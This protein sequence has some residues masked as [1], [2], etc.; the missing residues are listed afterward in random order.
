MQKSLQVFIWNRILLSGILLAFSPLL[1]GQ[2]L[3]GPMCPNELEKTGTTI[4]TLQSPGGGG[5]HFALMAPPAA[6]LDQY[7]NGPFD[8]P[9]NTCTNWVNGN[10]GEQNS[11]YLEGWSIPYRCV[12]TD[13]PL[14]TPITLT[15]GYDIKHS[16]KH[17][18]DYLTYFHRMS[19]H[20]VFCD[21]G[22]N[23]AECVTPANGMFSTF[24]IPAPSSAG[25]PVP[26]MPAASF[27]ALPAGEREMRLYGGVIDAITY[28]TEGNLNANQAETTINIV[29]R[30]TSATATLAW[31]GH[32]ASRLDW[33]EG[34][35]AGGIGGSPYHMR[36]ENWTLNNL[37]NQ[38]RSLSGGAVAPVCNI[39]GPD[40]LCAG[41]N[42]QY[43]VSNQ[44][45]I[46]YSWAVIS[47]GATIIGSNTGNCV[48]IQAG[49][50]D[51]TLEAT[52]TSNSGLC[53]N[54][55][56]EVDVQ[57]AGTCTI[58]GPALLCPGASTQYCG[59]IGAG[60]Y[61][62]S[63]S[64]AASIVGP[65]DGQCVTVLAD[66]NCNSSFTLNLFVGSQP[67][68]SMCFKQVPVRDITAPS[69][70]CPDDVTVSCDS[71]VPAVNTAAV[72]AGDNCGGAVTVTHLGD[73]PNG[74]CPKIITRTYQAEDA[75][76]N[77]NSCDQL[78]RVDDKTAPSI[79]CP[80]DVTVS[81]DSEVP[82]VNTAAVTAGDNCGGAVTV[83]HLG[84]VPSGSCP[85]IITR[86]YQAE[87]ACGNL[88]S[89]D[90]LITVDDKTAPS[91]TCP[92]DVTVTC[93]SDVL[94]ANVNDVTGS[95][96]CGGSVTVTHLGDVPSG[97]CPKIITRTYQ[98][99]DACGN[100]NSCDQLITVDDKTAPSITCPA[101]VTVTCDSDV[102]AANVND[103]TG[104]D[105]CGGSV[106]VTHLGDVP[107]GSCPK[108]ITRTYQAEDACGNLN[109]C[110]QLITVDDKT[111]PAITCPDNVTVSCDS[112]VPAVDV[113][114]VT[115][116]DN[117]GGSVTVTHL[118]DV[119][120]GSCP[121]IITRTYQAEDACGNLN[122]CDQL[123]TVDDKTAPAITC[124]DNVTVSC[125]S[126]VP[127]VD[128]D[129]V[130]A[131]DNCG[132]SVTVTHL[133]DVPNGSCPKI[134]TRT[135]QAEDA[136]G[137]LNS[138]D[139]L[140]TVD[141]KTAPAIT[142]PENVTVSCDSNV[143][144][145]DV[146]DVTASDNC[147][148]SVTVTHLG[149]V[150]NGSCP[151]IITRT[152]QA[153]DAC[154]NLNS[155]DQLITVDD[156][157]APSI[158]CPDN[159]TVSCDS[160]V[161]AVD[162]DDVTASDNCGGSVTVTHLDDVPNGSC[163]KIITRIY[164][165]EDAC[166][167]L[168]SCDQLITVDDK[169]APS[170]TCP[171]NVTVSCTSE[172][173]DV[174]VDDVTASDNCNGVVV[175]EH[176]SDD[177]SGVVC[178]DRY[179]VKRKYKATDACGNTAVC[180]Q[181]I[182]VYDDTPPLISCPADVTVSCTSEVPAA[183]VNDVTTSDNCGGQVNVTYVG[184]AVTDYVC[185]NK[186]KITR[187]YRAFDACGKSS[188]CFQYIRV[189]DE[190]PPSGTCPAD[191][192][193]SCV[194]DIPCDENDPKMEQAIEQ[195]KAAYSDNCGGDIEVT[196][197]S[198]GLVEGCSY[199]EGSGYTY[200]HAF[201]FIVSDGC[202]NSTTCE[203]RFSGACV[204]TY[205]QGFWGNPRGK[206]N[207]LN[208]SQILDTLMKLGPIF[209]G[210]SVDCGFEVKTWQ[211][212]LGILPAGGPSVPLEKNYK[213]N[214][215]K[216][217][218][219]NLVGQLIA[220]QL[221]VRYNEHFRD[222]HL[223]SL[224]LAESCALL[225]DAVKALGLGVDTAT[226]ADLIQL[227]NTYLASNCNGKVYPNGYGGQLTAALTALNE[228][229]DECR[230]NMPCEEDPEERAADSRNDTKVGNNLDN[231]TL[232]PNPVLSTLTVRMD[233]G[234]AGA[235]DL[236]CFDVN[237]RL[238][239][240]IRQEIASG[241]NALTIDVSGFKPG[242]YWLRV[243]NQQAAVTKR[244]VVSR[245]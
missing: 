176:L 17:A 1:T 210:D 159:V 127:A 19:P 145:V 170:I 224:I 31:G 42:A 32:I 6:N 240:L 82:A 203:V 137:N 80:D 98:A 81:C 12:M 71:E 216:K 244:F 207:G 119:P 146:D 202:G 43:C 181:V 26:G 88:N 52:L 242:I 191:I 233:S 93:D 238:I 237:G 47:G 236:Q 66:A 193:V 29:F 15:L 69:I 39:T 2:N 241:E 105:N 30:A 174:D 147:G 55:T 123:I 177:I 150:P 5:P 141:D 33:G 108:I 90:Q 49:S 3:G 209:V 229:W 208:T 24:P 212:I 40:L 199:V 4:S 205:T 217:I 11:H 211:C 222:L 197:A 62:W 114:D 168:N 169:T 230:N 97:S 219:N 160:N 68:G 155:C 59:P 56:F 245:D 162:V 139:Q 152:Y 132:G 86:T 142:C 226:V 70:T 79:T 228:Y 54:C 57:G 109:S 167:N 18:L 61:A 218:K 36:L 77:L 50:T 45:G 14:N 201:N 103:V 223:D 25:S 198:N 83:T 206:A 116:S 95:D 163:P 64:G 34:N 140:I 60:S 128:V 122:S 96:N 225:P 175:V 243:A 101:D 99:E 180:T 148:G 157:T 183:D 129:D 104:S 22:H 111:A 126:N 91:I 172:I 44:S 194:K 87:D 161:P 21:G 51:F 117:C 76:G 187:M 89:C 196:Y 192:T 189:S 143:P 136:C 135:Y 154:G 215:G 130:T 121:K 164:Q 186:Y 9:N 63:I 38:D 220:L 221:N 85:K 102:L 227:T 185:A 165:A 112:N 179:L 235:V 173:P 153:E 37:G 106:T 72:T 7:R 195:I 138:C 200:S 20:D 67:C 131:S 158:T 35:S 28:G 214:C 113:D 120:N 110:D 151:K 133:G 239:K 65:T 115:A 107:S 204:C 124:P 149:D 48:N 73:V 188:S 182:K 156:K 166:G 125:D 213:L 78:I 171:D 58:D 231:V 92:A 144:A 8:N 84:D 10:A 46:S 178:E 118:G 232:V 190:T 27:S 16:G 100:L 23:A 74:A 75:C 53:S 94:A 13:L 134:I 234:L 184:D 41:G